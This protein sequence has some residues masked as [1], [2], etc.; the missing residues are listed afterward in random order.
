MDP[1]SEEIRELGS[2]DLTYEVSGSAHALSNAIQIT[3]YNGRVVIGSW[4]GS[5]MLHL[6]LG[7]AFHRSHLNIIASQVSQIRPELAG[8]WT[9]ARRFEVVWD[10]I[11]RL[12]PSKFITHSIPFVE[13]QTAFELLD[14]NAAA[15]AV[16]VVLKYQ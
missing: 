11:R 5:N 2:M 9:K 3:G 15:D 7:S 12:K 6:N 13:A 1:R 8:R 14:S 4:Y 10:I 16:Q